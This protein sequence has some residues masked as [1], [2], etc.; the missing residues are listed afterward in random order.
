MIKGDIQSLDYSSCDLLSSFF[1]PRVCSEAQALG[2]G[3]SP[4]YLVSPH[5]SLGSACAFGET[6]ANKIIIIIIITIITIPTLQRELSRNGTP[7][8][9]E[10]LFQQCVKDMKSMFHG[11]IQY[12][13]QYSIVLVMGTPKKVSLI[14]GN[15]MWTS[16]MAWVVLSARPGDPQ[17]ESC[18]WGFPKFKKYPFQGVL[19]IRYTGVYIGIPKLWEST[20]SCSPKGNRCSVSQSQRPLAKPRCFLT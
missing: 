9:S 5:L 3:D 14:S 1:V 10:A 15:P 19:T 7:Y 6:H 11:Q 12:G 16:S 4:K 17:R 8:K 2:N 18:N 20:K 13:S